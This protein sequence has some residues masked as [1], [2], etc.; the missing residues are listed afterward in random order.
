M[1]LS[2]EYN[3]T[4]NWLFRKRSFLPL[5]LYVFATITL[6]FEHKEIL[7]FSN[8]FWALS[9]FFISLIG[10]GIR[11]LTI[12]YVPKATSGRNT[13]KQVAD[14]LNTTGIYSIVRHPL[15]L[16][17]FFMWLGIILYVGLLWFTFVCILIFWIYY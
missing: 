15:Y 14:V 3:K 16:G 7:D 6:L 8:I 17:N 1:T 9:C 13:D 11:I 5:I 4:G 12:G 2:E 10:L